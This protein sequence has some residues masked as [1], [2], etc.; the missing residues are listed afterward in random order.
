MKPKM[1][2]ISAIKQIAHEQDKTV[3][4]II[5]R[6]LEEIT[7]ASQQLSVTTK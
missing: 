6:L 7:L 3:D 5:Q 2:A 1:D 4:Q